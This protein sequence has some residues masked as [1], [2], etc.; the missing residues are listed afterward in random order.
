MSNKFIFFLSFLIYG[1]TTTKEM[2]NDI[3]HEVEKNKY[4]SEIIQTIDLKPVSI[5]F[6]DSLCMSGDFPSDFKS[7]YQ[8]TEEDINWVLRF[9]KSSQKGNLKMQNLQKSIFQYTGYETKTGNTKI[10][11]AVLTDKYFKRFKQFSLQ[12]HVYFDLVV[13]LSRKSEY[14]L[15]ALIFDKPKG[16]FKI[17][18]LNK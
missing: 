12:K 15:Y 13:D 18:V 14:Q 1:C 17:E 16:T 6:T 2:R 5:I 11:V 3:K 8:P 7:Y 4:H 9:I 10:Y